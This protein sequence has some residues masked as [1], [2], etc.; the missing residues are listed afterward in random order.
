MRGE[1]RGRDLVADFLQAQ[2]AQRGLVE[3]LGGQAVRCRGELRHQVHR[4]VGLVENA[5]RIGEL[6]DPAQGIVGV[7][8]G[9]VRRAVDGL[10]FHPAEGIVGVGDGVAGQ[11]AIDGV[12]VPGAEGDLWVHSHF[13]YLPNAGNSGRAFHLIHEFL[14]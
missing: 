11:R 2:I 14:E 9:G 13:I 4:I 8:G 12:E 6:G 1:V 7:D 3:Q 10:G 5:E